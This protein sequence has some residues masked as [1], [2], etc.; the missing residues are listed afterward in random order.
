MAR[1]LLAIGLRLPQSTLS[2][3]LRR[4]SRLFEPL[5]AAIARYQSE[6]AVAQADETSWPV[7]YIAG[8]DSN[9]DP[10]PRGSK[11]P[12]YWLWICLAANTVRMRILPTRGADS[13]AEL[14][15]GLGRHGPVILMC[16]R[17]SAYKAFARLCPDQVILVFCWAHVRRDWVRI[18]AGH[19]ELE[20]WADEW[21]DRI[22][23]LFKLDAERR[24]L[25]DPA[26]AMDAQSPEFDAIQAK[27]ETGLEELF[28]SAQEEGEQLTVE[29][30]RLE[31]ERRLDGAELARVDAKGRALGSLLKHQPGLRRFASD[32]RIPM[33]NN[34][35]ERALRGP[36]IA[37]LTSFGS[38]GPDG[39]R[40]AGLLF[41][42][43]ATMRLAG[44]NLYA[45]VLDW[46][47]ACARHGGQAPQDLDPWLPWRMS[48]S[49]RQE[50]SQP[51][52]RWWPQPAGAAVPA[53]PALPK[54]A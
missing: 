14:L 17:Y 8:A 7:Q 28:E 26:R 15:D 40:A 29:R 19:P 2:A 20:A 54:A 34:A 45:F 10:P 13:A 6:Q 41:G 25:W 43:L 44:L 32:P 39:A 38:G 21:V 31:G 16:D 52:A 46:L 49:R 23:Q 11:K 36:V 35:S 50:L 18:G 4:L 24:E 12:K 22:G 30:Q 53:D 9:K 5:E 51:P 48:E 1:D 42:V 3:G 33:D 27:L 37:R 47:G